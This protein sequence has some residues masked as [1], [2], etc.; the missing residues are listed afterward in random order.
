[1]FDVPHVWCSIVIV[2]LSF[3]PSVLPL[4]QHSSLVKAFLFGLSCH[5]FFYIEISNIMPQCGIWASLGC[6]L[7]YNCGSYN[8]DRTNRF[9]LHVSHNNLDLLEVLLI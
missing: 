2:F 8:I 3:F 6:G 9:D 1:M 4:A 5:S 7:A